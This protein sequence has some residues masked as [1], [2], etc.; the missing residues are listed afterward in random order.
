MDPKAHWD[1]VYRTK[2]PGEVSWYRPHLEIS[3]GLIEQAAPDRDARIIDVGGG[4]ATLVDDLLARG[5]RD[6]S[7]LDLSPTALAVAR[8]RLGATAER[9][10]V[11]LRRR[12]DLSLRGPTVRRLARPGRLSLP[13]R[14]GRAGRVRAAGGARGQAGW[15]RHR[16]DVRS[17]GPDPV[18]RP[19]GRPV[20]RRHAS[21]RVRPRIPAGRASHRIAPD[22]GRRDPA[23][24]LLLLRRRFSL[25][26][27]SARR[28]DSV[29]GMYANLWVAALGRVFRWSASSFSAPLMPSSTPCMFGFTRS[30][31]FQYSIALAYCRSWK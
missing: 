16:G 10:H 24:P 3:I 23:F 27:R 1:R 28:A 12:H 8:E 15:P 21:R 7:V 29:L 11:A 30:A 6:L 31:R 9:G 5:Y 18:Q 25:S 14:S 26:V 22:A 2:R 13:D 17:G 19:G 4:E 20:R